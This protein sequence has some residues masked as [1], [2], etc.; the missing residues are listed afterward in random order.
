MA[1]NGGEEEPPVASGAPPAS[2]GQSDA[3]TV[4]GVHHRHQDKTQQTTC[5]RFVR[6]YN[7]LDGITKSKNLATSPWYEKDEFRLDVKYKCFKEQI[8]Y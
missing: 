6:L 7:Q 4:R 3:A 1:Y 2:S 5:P 8:Y